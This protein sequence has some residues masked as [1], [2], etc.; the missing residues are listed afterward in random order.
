MDLRSILSCIISSLVMF[1]LSYFWHGIFFN[2]LSR[3]SYPITIFYIFA[4][5]A[6][7]FISIIVITVFRLDIVG[8]I[9]NNILLQGFISGVICGFFI[10]VVTV[11]IGVSFSKVMT[12][13]NI[14]VDVL[15]QM[16]EQGVGGIA[17]SFV[18]I[19]IPNSSSD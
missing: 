3:L 11:I 19:L 12:M 6:Y 2:D 5:I 13:K 18:Y 16:L 1:T 4:P 14:L 8:F 17:A 15:W 9:S 7:V 10:Y